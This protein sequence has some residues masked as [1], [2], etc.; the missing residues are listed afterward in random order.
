MDVFHNELSPRKL[1]ESRALARLL[2]DVRGSCVRLDGHWYVI[3]EYES[4][5]ITVEDI[6][7]RISLVTLNEE[8]PFSEPEAIAELVY[9][10]YTR[11]AMRS[12]C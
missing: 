8:P 5:F 7:Q 4:V 11:G 3:T 6:K 9:A 12:V 1:E 10:A 2:T